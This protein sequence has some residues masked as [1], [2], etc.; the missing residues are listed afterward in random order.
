MSTTAVYPVGPRK[1]R[2]TSQIYS[3]WKPTGRKSALN[4]PTPVETK[5]VWQ[6]EMHLVVGE[7]IIVK[8]EG[9]GFSI[10]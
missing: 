6:E 4:P 9:M 3:W 1:T 2:R 5:Q 8:R 10:T 7:H